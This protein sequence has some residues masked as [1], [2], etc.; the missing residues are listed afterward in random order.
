MELTN[1]GKC[2]FFSGV[3]FARKKKAIPEDHLRTC[4]VERR[5]AALSFGCLLP[6]QVGLRKRTRNSLSSLN[7]AGGSLSLS[8]YPGKER[9]EELQEGWTV[10]VPGHVDRDP[11]LSLYLFV[12]LSSNAERFELL[13]LGPV[14]AGQ[15]P[16]SLSLST[17]SLS[18]QRMREKIVKK[19]TACTPIFSFFCG[20][21]QLSGH[22]P[23]HLLLFHPF[24][25]TSFLVLPP[26]L[27][28]SL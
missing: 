9:F 19:N 23:R 2:V 20:R 6:F 12:S 10:A 11:S 16:S 8:L 1:T 21:S 26:L 25:G 27:S 24:L 4:M 17:F 14:E 7:W 5:L 13:W 28:F 3:A 22:H 15:Q 18:S